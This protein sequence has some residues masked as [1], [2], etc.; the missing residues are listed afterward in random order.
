MFLE[1][2]MCAVYRDIYAGPIFFEG[3]IAVVNIR[4]VFYK[5]FYFIYVQEIP[6][7]VFQLVNLPLRPSPLSDDGKYL[8]HSQPLVIIMMLIMIIIGCIVYIV[9]LIISKITIRHL[10]YNILCKAS[11]LN[12]T[13]VYISIFCCYYQNTGIWAF[14]SGS[15]LFVTPVGF[16]LITGFSWQD[17]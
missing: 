3:F 5:S 7:K 13:K 2:L 16:M 9:N 8:E 17:I 12:K 15:S 1:I 10:I 14:V 11:L 6:Y 4:Y